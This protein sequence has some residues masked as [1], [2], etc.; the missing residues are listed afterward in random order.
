MVLFQPW[1]TTLIYADSKGV[2]NM[3]KKL[4]LILAVVFI[5]ALFAGCGGDSPSA[6]NNTPANTPSSNASNNT[7][8][9][10]GGSGDTNTPAPVV[11]DGSPLAKGKFT[12]NAAGY[13]DSK[14]DY[15]LPLTTSDDVFTYWTTCWTPQY[16]AEDGLA[17]MPFQKGLEDLTGVHIEY[18]VV[19]SDTRNENFSVLLAADDLRDIMD[20]AMYFYTDSARSAIEDGWFINF[21]D[22]RDY[23]PNYLYELWARDDID[24]LKY[25]RVDDVTWPAM[26]GMLVEPAPGSGYMLR[27]DWMDDLNLGKAEDIKTFDQWHDVLTAFKANGVQ[28]PME[29]F[30]TVEITNGYSFAGYNTGMMVS[31]NGLPGAKIIDGEIKFCL[32]TPDDFDAITMVSKWYA[33]GLI[34]HNYS[35]FGSTQ[36]L[37]TEITTGVTGCCVFTPSEVE[38]W[39]AATDDPDCLWMPTPRIKKEPNQILKYGQKLSHFHYGS[40][41]VSANCA[42]IPLIC[43]WLDWQWSEEGCLYTNWGVEGL[44]WEYDENG[45]RMLTD[46]VLHNPDGIGSAWV[47]VL[48]ACDGLRQPCLNIHK[49]NYAY[50]GGEIYLKMFDTWE[51]PDYSGEYDFPTGVTYTPEQAEELATYSNDIATYISEN[52]LGFLDGSK[53]LTEWDSYIAGLSGLGIETVLGIYQDAYEA[54]IA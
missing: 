10:N 53:P 42:D 34:D 43:S 11:D 51:V 18:D 41:S 47:M 32:T 50:P 9:D 20:Q 1:N 2:K 46:F 16:I 3:K 13:T 14:Y 35:S 49:R 15:E 8:T 23:M 28:W 22:Y 37:T 19:S 27:Q 54:Y 25:G 33:E 21:Y 7:S 48:Y 6:E 30:K 38:S 4:A 24:V 31:D 29:I 26:Y 17:S 12:F 5:V 52:F 45:N 39:Q 44:T 36:D 40:A